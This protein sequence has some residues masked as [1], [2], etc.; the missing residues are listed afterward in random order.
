MMNRSNIMMKM[1]RNNYKINRKI[2]LLATPMFSMN[3]VA[4][5][6]PIQTKDL[7]PLVPGTLDWDW[8]GNTHSDF[9][10]GDGNGDGRWVQNGMDE[11]EVTPDGTV[12]VGTV[13]DEGGRSIG[14]YKNG[15]VN[16]SC[17]GKN[18]RGAAIAVVVGAP[19]TKR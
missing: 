19:A 7:P 1:N 12:I 18:N 10:P 4:G 9:L 16:R 14:I 5:A 2:I 8:V 6:A 3:F 17:L 13:W 11:M 15:T